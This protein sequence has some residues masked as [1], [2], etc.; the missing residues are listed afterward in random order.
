M[1][2]LDRMREEGYTSTKLHFANSWVH[3]PLKYTPLSVYVRDAYRI[4]T[5]PLSSGLCFQVRNSRH[6]LFFCC[7][8]SNSVALLRRPLLDWGEL[9]VFVIRPHAP[10]RDACTVTVRYEYMYRA[11]PDIYIFSNPRVPLLWNY[12]ARPSP[13]RTTVSIFPTRPAPHP[14]PLNRHTRHCNVNENSLYFS[15]KVLGNI[16]L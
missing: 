15:L 4:S 13:P 5:W 1:E 8:L 9:P 16:A 14:R 7:R 11:T 3:K 2:Y 10:N 6:S 12:L